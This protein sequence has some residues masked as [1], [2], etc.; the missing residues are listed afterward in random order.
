ML[1]VHAREQWRSASAASVW[2]R[3]DDWYHPAVDAVLEA[4][5]A[6]ADPVPA[7]GRL[8]EVRSECGVGIGESIDDLACLYR[9]LRLEGP[10]LDVVRALCDGWAAAQDA[11]PVNAQCVDPETGLPTVEYLR[12]RLA[13]TYGVAARRGERA[14]DRHALLVVDVAV[15]MRDP[16]ARIARSAVVGQALVQSYGDGQPMASL[17]E[18]VFLLLVERDAELG[19]RATALRDR[20]TSHARRLGVETLVRQPPRVWVESL[21]PTHARLVELL[22]HLAR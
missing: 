9:S 10:S 17:G 6:G 20:L 7:A 3:P 8:G 5:L 13:E 21:P 16:W 12:V 22:S 11:V 2:L 15:G 18:G 14:G 4:L 19:T 1:P